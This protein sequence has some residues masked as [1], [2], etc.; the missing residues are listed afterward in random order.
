MNIEQRVHSL[1]ENS[2]EVVRV[3]EA[4]LGRKLLV[5]GRL[6]ALID[7]ITTA[8]QAMNEMEREAGPFTFSDDWRA[9]RL[10]LSGQV[11]QI[12]RMLA[13]TDASEKPCHTQPV[14]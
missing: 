9:L 5:A 1:A 2:A 3:V 6:P 7:V 11:S 14:T 10:T 8:L 12:Q 4:N 13:G